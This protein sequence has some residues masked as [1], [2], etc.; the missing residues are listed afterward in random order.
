MEGAIRL[1]FA[2][3]FLIKTYAKLTNWLMAVAL[4]TQDTKAEFRVSD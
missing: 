1:F 2:S 4:F 3:F